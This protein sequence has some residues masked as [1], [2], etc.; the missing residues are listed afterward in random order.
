MLT[1][2]VE[3]LKETIPDARGWPSHV[4]REAKV[5]LKSLVVEEIKGKM[6]S[7]VPLAKEDLIKVK[8]TFNKTAYDNLLKGNLPLING[9]PVTGDDLAETSFSQQ[10]IN[11]VRKNDGGL[12]EF[13]VRFD[14]KKRYEA[15][16]SRPEG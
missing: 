11:G 2:Y 7:P 3:E 6:I 13:R 1:D 10:I 14:R 12:Q 5:K 16:I 4:K 15:A 9:D 8:M